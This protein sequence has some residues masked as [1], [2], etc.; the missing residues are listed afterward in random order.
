M[1]KPETGST[2]FEAKFLQ[3]QKNVFPSMIEILAGDL[4]VSVKSINELGIG[5]YPAWQSWVWPE[6]DDKGNVIGLGHR[7][8]GGKKRMEEGSKRGLVYECAGRIDK[9][10]IDKNI[11]AGRGFIRAYNAGVDCPLCGKRKW[12]LVSNDNPHNPSTVICGHTENGAAKYIENSGYLHFI[13]PQSNSSRTMVLFNSDKPYIVV[14]GF[15]DVLAA[16]DMDYVAIGRPSATGG[17]RFLSSLL[18]GQEVIIIGENDD[19]GRR[20]AHKVFQSLK[21]V[22]SSTRKILPPPEFKDIRQWHPTTGVFEA[23]VSQHAEEDK[24]D[25]ILESDEQRQ[26]AYRW[27]E[28]HYE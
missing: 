12:C 20:G 19:I 23:W 25:R 15:S 27:M 3:Y 9:K 16:M 21:G 6:R 28:E 1:E 24:K 14:E 17:N 7:L 5:F 22:T 11:L 26:L 10:Q 4:G 18:R 13:K 8:P 2:N